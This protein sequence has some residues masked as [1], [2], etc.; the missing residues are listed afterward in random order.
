MEGQ[1]VLFLACT[2]KIR[3]RTVPD[4]QD[5]ETHT[6]D[7][8]DFVVDSRICSRNDGSRSA[9]RILPRGTIQYMITNQWNVARLRVTSIPQSVTSQKRKVP[10]RYVFTCP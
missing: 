6:F 4:N 10:R 7:H 9:T 5:T 8:L 2:L 1:R 3:V